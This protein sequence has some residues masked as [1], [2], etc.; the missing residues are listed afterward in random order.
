LFDFV[1]L[2]IQKMPWFDLMFMVGMEKSCHVNTVLERA[3]LCF[4]SKQKVSKLIG[5]SPVIFLPSYGQKY[6]LFALK[7]FVGEFY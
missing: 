2:T 3:I 5:L 7:L 6:Q 4:F 1:S